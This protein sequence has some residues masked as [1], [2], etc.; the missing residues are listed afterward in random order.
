MSWLDELS[1][2]ERRAKARLAELE[3]QVAQIEPLLAEYNEVQQV[4]VRLGRER[5]AS[6]PA[7]ESAVTEAT[8]PG[9]TGASASA[10]TKPARPAARKRAARKPTESKPA[11]K[12]VA[13]RPTTAAAPKAAATR[14]TRR[15]RS[16]ARPGERESQLLELVATRPG[17]T[18]SQ[19]ANELGVDATGLYGI[20]R[21]LEGKGR[22]TK[23]G[24]GLTLTPATAPAVA[25][26]APA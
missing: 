4:L 5:A 2:L 6:L 18:V 20:V 26:P 15:R 14:G 21:R 3:P 22:L 19:I 10:T 13:R 9:T 16:Q 25:T 24:T 1:E 23:Q 11:R 17:V 7:A 8:P 12:P